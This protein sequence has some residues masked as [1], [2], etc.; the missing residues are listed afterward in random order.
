MDGNNKRQLEKLRDSTDKIA[1]CIQTG[2]VSKG[3]AWFS[4]GS[5]IMKML[6]YPMIAIN[7]DE[8]RN[9]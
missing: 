4:L 8:K 9:N 5:T 7:L 2:F 1:N 6:E 3:E